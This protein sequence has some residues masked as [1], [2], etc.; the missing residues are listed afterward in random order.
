M[1]RQLPRQVRDAEAASDAKIQEIT[2]GNAPPPGDPPT[3]EPAATAPPT[4]P[5]VTPPAEQPREDWKAQFFTLR[6]KYNAEV[7]R[8]Q[9]DVKDRDVTIAARDA[10][11]TD[12]RAQL[13]AKPATPPG[14]DPLVEQYG[15]D[16]VQMVRDIAANATREVRDEL[17]TMK[18]AVETVGKT[19]EKTTAAETASAAFYGALELRIPDWRKRDVQPD[20]HHYLNQKAP[21]TQS[22]RQQLLVAARD[23]GDLETVVEFFEDFERQ[24]TAPAPTVVV[25]PRTPLAA[26]ETPT[27]TS[28]AT[29][30]PVKKTYTLDE[31]TLNFKDI[32]LGKKYT[33]EQ[34]AALEVDMFAAGQEGRVRSR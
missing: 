8:L 19:A 16:T 27:T 31:I 25:P 18:A 17:N 28:R 21:F 34:A 30:E 15:A 24:N 4:T 6:G 10:T 14:P 7:P 20:W 11:I 32:A 26:Q 13:A 2:N 5:P 1:A 23:R 33:K 9:Q 22:T 29:V 3:P 12:L